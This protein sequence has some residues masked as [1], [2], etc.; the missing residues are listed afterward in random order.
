MPAKPKTT[1]RR[2]FLKTSILTAVS[3][4]FPAIVPRTVFG[5][6]A[7]SNRIALGFIGCGKRRLSSV[8]L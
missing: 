2:D 8:P 4:G 7:P 3:V 6:N 1:S 5:E